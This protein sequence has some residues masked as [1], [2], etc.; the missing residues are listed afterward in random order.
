[1]KLKKN[2]TV[3]V[4][5]GKDKKKQGKVLVVDKKN[6]RI[7]VEGVNIVTKH[8]KPSRANQQGGI[9]KKEAPINASNVMYLHNGTPTRLGYQITYEENEGKK[10][11]IKKRIA[12][13]TGDVID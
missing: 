4:I 11:K 13:S 10:I 3:Q 1:M 7:I 2:D 8:Q 9:A 12:K 5:A 6:N